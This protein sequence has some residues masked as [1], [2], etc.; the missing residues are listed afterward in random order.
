[1]N[2]I[3]TMAGTYSRFRKF[4][5]EIP[6]YL[7]PLGNRTV[8]H[9]VMKEFARCR[10]FDNVLL[11]ANN[12]D[13][14]FYYQVKLTAEELFGESSVEIVYIDDTEG[15]ALSCAEGLSKCTNIDYSSPCIVHNIDTVLLNRDFNLFLNMGDAV[16]GV[17]IFEASSDSYS[18]VLSEGDRVVAIREKM[19]ISD[20][21]SSGCYA[22][23]NREIL[24]QCLNYKELYISQ[25]IQVLADNGFVVKLIPTYPNKNSDTVVL[26]TPEEYI[27]SM[28]QFYY[29]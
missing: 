29:V 10:N 3:L 5:Y 18:Y 2:L 9:Y 8:L 1:M 26:G 25:C 23:V 16:C 15:Q 22:F 20:T 27:N 12:R 21:A 24:E 19:V 4:S 13:K 14:R 28:N 11:I 6:K 7:L 17:D